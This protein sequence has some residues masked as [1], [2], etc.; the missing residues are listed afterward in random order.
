MGAGMDLGIRDIVTPTFKSFQILLSIRLLELLHNTLEHSRSGSKIVPPLLYE[1]QH[2]SDFEQLGG[3]I[4]HILCNLQFAWSDVDDPKPPAPLAFQILNGVPGFLSVHLDHITASRVPPPLPVPRL[5]YNRH[6]RR[7]NA[8]LPEDPMPPGPQRQ[9]QNVM[10]GPQV[11]NA[12]SGVS[13]GKSR[14]MGCL[15]RLVRTKHT[16]LFNSSQLQFTPRKPG[17]I[18]WKNG[19]GYRNHRQSWPYLPKSWYTHNDVDVQGQCCGPRPP[20]WSHNS[21]E[22]AEMHHRPSWQSSGREPRNDSRLH[23]AGVE[24]APGGCFDFARASTPVR[25]RVQ[26]PRCASLSRHSSAWSPSRAACCDLASNCIIG[27]TSSSLATERCSPRRTRLADVVPSP[28]EP[29]ASQICDTSTLCKLDLAGC[30]ARRKGD[31][32]AAR[33]RAQVSGQRRFDSIG[34]AVLGV[35]RM[36]LG[37]LRKRVLIAERVV[38]NVEQLAKMAITP[39]EH[40]HTCSFPGLYIIRGRTEPVR[41][42]KYSK[43]VEFDQITYHFR[44]ICVPGFRFPQKK[45]SRHN[46]CVPNV[47]PDFDSLEDEKSGRK[48]IGDIFLSPEFLE[49]YETLTDY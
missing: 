37:V 11:Q 17:L 49:K 28:E 23:C 36:R 29:A 32:H 14:K 16:S 24:S 42:S 10:Y 20:S 35:G 47:S 7:R 15:E 6:H 8:I 45:C 1:A 18:H 41:K 26:L 3:Y 25:S 2:L 22:Y 46:I 21:V 44:Y 5:W 27:R 31:R 34:A 39:D 48:K 13:L 43:S 38:N 19:L 33:S 30:Q 4:N 9:Y 40:T 12:R